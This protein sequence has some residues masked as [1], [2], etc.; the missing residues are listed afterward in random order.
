MYKNI[1]IDKILLLKHRGWINKYLTIISLVF[2]ILFTGVYLISLGHTISYRDLKPSYEELKKS[3]GTLVDT[4]SSNPKHKYRFRYAI[5]IKTTSNNIETFDCMIKN[6]SECDEYIF[7]SQYKFSDLIVD[8]NKANIK[9]AVADDGN[10][11]IYELSVNNVKL[12][13]YNQAVHA[14][15]KFIQ[16]TDFINPVIL[17]FFT[18]SAL[19]FLIC[20]FTPFIFNRKLTKTW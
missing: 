4:R 11:I 13:S 8:G 15:S 18:Y 7:D 19:M 10:K 5:S 12:I 2:T 6:Q 20:F 1:T 17:H 14:Y 9:Y 3:D 16:N